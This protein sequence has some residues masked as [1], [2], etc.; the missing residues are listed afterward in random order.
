MSAQAVL[1]IRKEEL[2]R[3][4]AGLPAEVEAW[5]HRTQTDLDYD[6]HVSQLRAIKILVE[7][8]TQEQREL[9]NGLDP[10][11]D[12]AVFQIRAFDLV[13]NVIRSQKAWDFFR[14][15]LELRFSP[16]FK[17]VLW[18]ADTV[19]WDCYDPVLQAARSAGI[20]KKDELREPPLT[21]L[22]AEF[23]PAT[24]VRGQRPVDMRNYPLGTSYL[25]IPVI[26]MPWDHVQNSWEFLA[27]HHEVGHDLE[28]DLKLREPLKASLKKSLEDAGVPAARVQRWLKWQ[29]EVFADL[30]ALQLGGPAFAEALMD[31]LLLP[32]SMVITYDPKDPHPTPYPRMLMNAAYIPTL[33]PGDQTLVVHGQQIT[34]RWQALYDS[35]SKFDEID[36]FPTVFR[37][38][39]DTP[40]P[41]ALKG[42]TPRQ[43]MEYKLADHLRTRQAVGYMMTGNDKPTKQLRPRHCVSAGRLAV[44]QAALDNVLSDTLLI[45]IN[46]RTM[47]LVREHAPAGERA[48]NS[49][50]PHKEFIAS[51]AKNF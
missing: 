49:S 3:R 47:K 9:L 6:A 42:K 31:L 24:W 16:T 27:L 34:E 39:M 28:A 45:D 50:T 46:Q 35:Q 48:S 33:I 5:R 2:R 43:L 18:V 26:E 11:G 41:E 15:K 29:G 4:I 22:T 14:D 20:L 51:F 7:V 23:S 32:A 8:F 30:V 13:Q 12:A 44:T 10:Q 19:A 37:A 38:L 21:Y 40:L 17:E 1:V 25:P 36:D